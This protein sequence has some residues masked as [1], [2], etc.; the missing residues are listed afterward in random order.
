MAAASIVGL[1]RRVDMESFHKAGTSWE[2]LLPGPHFRA[3]LPSHRCRKDFE[4]QLAA[5]QTEVFVGIL[6]HNSSCSRDGCGR[7]RHSHKTSTYSTIAAQSSELQ[8]CLPPKT[9]LLFPSCRPYTSLSQPSPRF[10]TQQSLTHPYHVNNPQYNYHS[11]SCSEHFIAHHSCFE[12]PTSALPFTDSG[13][14]TGYRSDPPGRFTQS[15]AVTFSS[16]YRCCRMA[17]S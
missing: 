11:Y 2:S 9:H 1:H 5:L 6:G 13:D 7:C 16:I 15:V 8:Y 14:L 3:Y 12:T 17:S 10:R 4:K